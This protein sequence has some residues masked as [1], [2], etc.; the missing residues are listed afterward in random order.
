MSLAH[1]AR[2][3]GSR[4]KFDEIARF[5]D[6]CRRK[7]STGSASET[8]LIARREFEAREYEMA[9]NGWRWDVMRACIEYY[10]PEV[11]GPAYLG[12]QFI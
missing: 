6:N 10:L 1:I 2:Q 9:M 12:F 5:I 4:S 11:G 7:T 8:V 3:S